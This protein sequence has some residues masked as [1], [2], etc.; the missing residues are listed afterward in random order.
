ML[1][2]FIVAK[3]GTVLQYYILNIDNFNCIFIICRGQMFA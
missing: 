1:Y 3:N 2:G